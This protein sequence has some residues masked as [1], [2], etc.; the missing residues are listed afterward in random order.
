MAE[1]TLKG[2]KIHTSGEILKTGSKLSNFTLTKNDLSEAQLE[3][4]KGKKKVLNIF[5]SLD[6]PVCAASVRRFNDEVSKL[7]NTVIL[8]ISA[9]LPFA[10]GRFCSTEGIEN[11]TNLSTFRSSFPKDYSVEISDGPLKGLCSRAVIVADEEDNVIYSEQ[12]PE[13]AQ[14]PDY[15][16]AKLAVMG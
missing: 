7:G 16:K 12:V 3:E 9:D 1:I 14:E 4:F 10:H 5:P 15:E 6:T 2:N 11:S 13:I 8:N